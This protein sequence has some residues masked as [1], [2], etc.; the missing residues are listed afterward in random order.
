MHLS[1]IRS[2][3]NELFKLCG[4]FPRLTGRYTREDQSCCLVTNIYIRL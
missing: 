1:V 4:M 2:N 3:I